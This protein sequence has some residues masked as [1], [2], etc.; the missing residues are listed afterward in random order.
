MNTHIPAES[1]SPL[2]WL[3][4][5]P[6]PLT[7]DDEATVA[8]ARLRHY[9]LPALPIVKQG[10]VVGILNERAL[11]TAM[12]AQRGDV[13]ELPCRD[14]VGPAVTAPVSTPVQ[15]AFWLLRREDVELLTVVDLEGRYLGVITRGRVVEA[16]ED[17]RRPRLVGGMATPLGVHL[18]SVHQ[19]GGASDLGLVLTGVCLVGIGLAARLLVTLLYAFASRDPQQAMAAGL[20]GA[21]VAR[22][23][24]PE[25][26]AWL[27]PAQLVAFLVMLR[28]TPLAGYHSGEHQTVHALERGL[29]LTLDN[30]GRMPR[31]HL[32]C[33]TNL[34]VL[35]GLFG[36]FVAVLAGS[37]SAWFLLPLVAAVILWRKLGLF[38]Q[39]Y[40][41]TRPATQRQLESGIAAAEAL[42]QRHRA[43]LGAVAPLWLRIWNRG[44]LQVAGGILLAGWLGH[45]LAILSGHWLVHG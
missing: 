1:D 7:P 44:L 2:S 28:M 24:V 30:V 19:R 36:G 22:G 10:H 37:L 15:E 39:D 27:G 20:S 17:Q 6:E 11:L 43:Q 31:A 32:R 3:L 16:V 34:V 38:A 35:V 5:R 13:S 42:L 21:L 45:R 26:A 18:T 33:G 23:A 41:T 14:L 25:P 40:F 29:P 4:E 9:N 8:A 12:A